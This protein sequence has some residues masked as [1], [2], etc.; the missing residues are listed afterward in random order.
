[1]TSPLRSIPG[2]PAHPYFENL[3]ANQLEMVRP[4]LAA[5]PVPPAPEG[6]RVRLLQPGDEEAYD[7]LFHLA[8]EDDGRFPEMLE[9]VLEGGFFVVEHL[10]TG[11]LVASSQAWRG[12][13]SPRHPESGQMGWL[14]GDPSHAGKG[15]GAL[16]AALATNRL[17]AEGY[18]RPFLGSEDFRLAAILIYL[19][20]GWQP[21]LYC[22]E[23]EG[24]WRSVF[25]R[26]GRCFDAAKACRE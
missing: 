3:H 9:R 21:Y 13:S 5:V 4:S 6:Y 16:V 19:R 11:Q 10:V 12:S 20:L 25:A 18:T 17:A 22:D 2:R 23:M 1:M 15:L 26:L 7:Q 14:V 24:R 8:F